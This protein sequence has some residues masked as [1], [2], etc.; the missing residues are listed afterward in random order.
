MTK[1]IPL[2]F[3]AKSVERSDHLTIT[4]NPQDP[5][6]I[7]DSNT[8]GVNIVS[9]SDGPFMFVEWKKTALAATQGDTNVSFIAKITNAGIA[10]ANEVV[11]DWN[12]PTDWS[13]TDTAEW[14]ASSGYAT[15]EITDP[16]PVNGSLEKTITFAINSDANIGNETV[17]FTAGCC[18]LIEKSHSINATTLIIQKQNGG[19]DTG[20]NG[21]LLRLFR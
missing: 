11:L 15:L 9:L 14:I 17:Y 20:R 7:P 3:I 10:D 21:L 1:T 2:S 6:A 12:F 4:L 13:V 8:V 16:L 19:G 5:A 18:S